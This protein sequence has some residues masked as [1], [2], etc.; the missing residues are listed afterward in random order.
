MNVITWPGGAAAQPGRR[1]PAPPR[2]GEDRCRRRCRLRPGVTW[3]DRSDRTPAAGFAHP[4]LAGRV[5]ALGPD[6][7][8]WR[9]TGERWVQVAPAG[10]FAAEVALEDAV[11]RTMDAAFQGIWEGQA[12]QTIVERSAGPRDTGRCWRPQPPGAAGCGAIRGLAGSGSFSARPWTTRRGDDQ[13]AGRAQRAA[14]ARPSG[15]DAFAPETAKACAVVATTSRSPCGIG[16]PPPVITT[17]S[18]TS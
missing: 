13:V 10:A 1:R 3:H 18:P 12:R 16:S 8:R 15:V 5:E 14:G 2:E 4:E 11:V 17:S 9:W 6:G 7:S